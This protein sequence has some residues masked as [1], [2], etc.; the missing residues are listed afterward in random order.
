MAP[1]YPLPV[2]LC[3]FPTNPPLLELTWDQEMV[4][5]YIQQEHNIF[6]SDLGIS[7]NVSASHFSRGMGKDSVSFKALATGSLTMLQ[8]VHGPR[9]FLVIRALR[10]MSISL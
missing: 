10:R 4:C 1:D 7:Y 8:W 3:L 5:L 9:I 6:I 2:Y